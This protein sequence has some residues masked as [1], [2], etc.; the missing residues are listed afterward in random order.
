MNLYNLIFSD[1]VMFSELV[2]TIE[3]RNQENVVTVQR[4]NLENRNMMLNK[5]RNPKRWKSVHGKVNETNET[6]SEIFTLHCKQLK[7]LFAFI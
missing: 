7:R 2:K 4:I 6:D 3:E 1:G 5:L